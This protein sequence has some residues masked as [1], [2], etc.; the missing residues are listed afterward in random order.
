M[1]LMMPAMDGLTAIPLLRR[2]NPNLHIIATSGL[3]ST[4]SMAKAE[5]LGFQGFL[6]KPFTARELLQ[7]LRHE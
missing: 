5:E 3:N 6:P 1:D 4:D 7:L 2:L